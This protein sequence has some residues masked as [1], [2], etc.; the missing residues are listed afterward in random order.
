[1]LER[2][3]QTIKSCSFLGHLVLFEPK[4]GYQKSESAPSLFVVRVE[5]IHG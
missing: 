3:S 4:P 5:S 1:M 2:V